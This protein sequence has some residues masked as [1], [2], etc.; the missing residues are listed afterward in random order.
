M[1]EVIAQSI[2][3][4]P[5]INVVTELCFHW[6]PSAG[7]AEGA[8]HELEAALALGGP[9]EVGICLTGCLQ[10]HQGHFKVLLNCRPRFKRVLVACGLSQYTTPCVNPF[11]QTFTP[12]SSPFSIA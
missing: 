11:D 10:R 6:E 8:A 1:Q 4:T 12:F 7:G 5:L 3:Q 9:D 2:L